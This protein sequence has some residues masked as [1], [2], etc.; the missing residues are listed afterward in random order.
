MNKNQKA[1]FADDL[2]KLFKK[3]DRLEEREKTDVVENQMKLV[4]ARI[5]TFNRALSLFGYFPKVYVGMDGLTESVEILKRE[6]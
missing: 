2:L 5:D 1:A 3:L 4:F 6:G